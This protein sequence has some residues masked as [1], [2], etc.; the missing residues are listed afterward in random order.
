MKWYT[1]LILIVIAFLIWR[2][3]FEIFGHWIWLIM[4]CGGLILV[5]LFYKLLDKK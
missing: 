2:G 3:M 1:W 5:G 4:L